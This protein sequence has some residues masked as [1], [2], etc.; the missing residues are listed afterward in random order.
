MTG[1]SDKAAKRASEKDTRKMVLSTAIAM[2]M[3][4]LSPGRSGNVSA[5]FDGGMLITPTGLSYEEMEPGDIVFVDADGTAAPKQ[6]K[7]SSEW[8]LHQEVYKARK[9]CHAIVHAHSQYATVLACARRA[10]PAFHYMVALGGGNDIPCVPYATYGSLELAKLVAKGLKDRDACL[11]AN[12]GQ[13][14]IG[15]SLSQALELAHEVE[16]LSH[17]Y[18]HVL[19]I[20]GANLLSNDEM[21][22]VAT[23]FKSYGRRAQEA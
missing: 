3:A 1:K 15:A 21:A 12:H 4:G 6:R 5:R 9:D 23:K 14:A 10:I 22:R 2:N 20:D 11:L 19:A 16:V 17:Q 8:Q 18:F 7:P 13:V